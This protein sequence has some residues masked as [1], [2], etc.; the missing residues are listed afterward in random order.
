ML[1]QRVRTVLSQVEHLV[2]KLVSEVV[3]GRHSPE[4]LSVPEELLETN[5]L[6]FLVRRQKA[7][8]A[9]L[10]SG[11]SIE[12]VAVVVEQDRIHAV[13]CTQGNAPTLGLEG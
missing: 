2:P 12:V 8:L 11:A 7:A 10:L 6:F 3:D 4:V 1:E 9:V 5:H 13:G